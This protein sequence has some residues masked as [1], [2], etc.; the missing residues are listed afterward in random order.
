LY[1][2]DGDGDHEI[3]IATGGGRVHAYQHDGSEVAGWPVQ[4]Q[5]APRWHVGQAAEVATS[6]LADGFIATVAVG[7]LEG[8]GSPEVVAASGGGFVYAWHADGTPVSGWPVEMERR[9]AE[10]F[11]SNNA[12]DN[13]FAGAPTLYDVDGDG[14]LEVVAAGMDQRVYVWDYSGAPFGP[15]PLE[16]CAE[17]LCGG[18]GNRI[19]NSVTIGDVDGDGDPEFG[20]GSNEATHDGKRSISYLFDGRT[21]VMAP[22][23][24]LEES[25]LVGEAALLPIVG[26]GHPASLAFADVDG[27]GDL[28]I[29]SM[30]M[31]G[32]NPLYQH[33]G[34]VFRELP[35]VSSLFSEGANTSES[36]LTSMSN[37]PS[38][39][40]LDGDGHPE[41]FV[42]GAGTFYLLSLPLISAYDYQ[43]VAA[44]WSGAT[45][46]FMEGWPRQIEDLQFLVAPA[47]A[48]VSGDGKPEAIFGSAGYMLYAWDA[49]GQLAEGWPHFTG[50][51]LLGSP[52]VGDID[53]DGYV[54]VVASSREGYLFAWH[55][56]GHADQAIQWASIHHDAQNTGNYETPIEKQAGPPAVEECAEGECCCQSADGAVL[57]GWLAGAAAL[58]GRRRRA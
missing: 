47:V 52:A 16:F 57:I 40:D 8:D 55:T 5:A 17:E 49:T 13:G 4:T 51:W 37:N 21:G 26:E 42:G 36:S 25:G 31:L 24:P 19:I 33:D 30:V 45:G 3:V 41:F 7:D 46:E 15:Y 58:F 18:Q 14:T 50:N 35:Y 1:D 32:Q 9:S 54:E 29:A 22:G 23:W 27:N 38:F 6:A 34:S 48:D 56:K 28:E 11:T 44:A 12:W 20:V 2:I 10:E 43:H 53:G 39:G